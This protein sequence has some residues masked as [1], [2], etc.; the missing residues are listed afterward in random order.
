MGTARVVVRSLAERPRP[1]VPTELLHPFSGHARGRRKADRRID[2]RLDRNGEAYSHTRLQ[3]RCK[4]TDRLAELLGQSDDDAL[5]AT[6]PHVDASA[7]LPEGPSAVPTRLASV[8]GIGSERAHSGVPAGSGVWVN[9][10]VDSV[11]QP[12]SEGNGKRFRR[13]PGRG[14]VA[15][16]T[17][18]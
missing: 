4:S 7:R 11:R 17:Q 13:V 16:W 8:L 12:A 14:P 5:A 3:A 2:N 10:R 18:R 15:C 9:E 1:E 6:R